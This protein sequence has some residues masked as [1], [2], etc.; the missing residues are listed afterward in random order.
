MCEDA[1]CEPRGKL[2]NLGHTPLYVPTFPWNGVTLDPYFHQFWNLMLPFPTVPHIKGISGEAVPQPEFPGSPACL[3]P[4]LRLSP[5]PVYTYEV[6]MV[7][8]NF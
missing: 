8:A 4:L 5:Q 3:S 1:G 7:L 2:L 6:E